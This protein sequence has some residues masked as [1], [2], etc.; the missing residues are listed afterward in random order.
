MKARLPLFPS[1]TQIIQDHLVIGGCD[2][3]TLADQ[4][5]TPLYVYDRA[6]MDTAAE[7]Y[8]HFLKAY[9]P[10]EWAVTYAGKAFLC[11][12]I[13]RWAFSQGFSVDCTG[14]GEIAI[15]AGAGLPAENI[16]VHGVNKSADDLN[17]ALRHAGTLVVDNLSELA[18]LLELSKTGT[19]PRLWLRLQP[20]SSVDTHA[21]TQTGHAGSKFGMTREQVLEAVR[22][23]RRHDLPLD[24][25]HF[26]QGSQFRDPEPLGDG[27]DRVLDLVQEIGFSAAWH[28]SPGGGWGVS[29]HESDLPHPPIELYVRFITANLLAGCQKRKLPLPRLHLEPGRSLIAR[30]AVA[31]Y[32]V[33]TV[34]Q[35]SGKTWL[36]VDGG[37]ADNPRHALYGARYSCLTVDQPLSAG[38]GNVSIAGPFCESGDVLIENIPLRAVEE[39]ELV[40][41]PVSGAYH[42][43]MASN[44]NGARRPAVLLLEN[45]QSRLIQARETTGDLTRRDALEMV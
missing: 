27:I 25:L 17:A 42:L 43:S 32:R 5:G 14:A 9:W 34:K 7:Q 18:R 21:Y 30:A 39:N 37:L 44:Y 41:V 12:A 3:H 40:A 26:H 13:A 38:V 6:D 35:V 19:L 8:R 31:I 10:G 20:G 29:Y 2:L 16:L 15:A 4:Y 24:G 33:G 23:C 36:L 28:L 22:L 11:S 1:S 45:G